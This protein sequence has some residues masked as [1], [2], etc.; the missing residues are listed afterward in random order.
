MPR[1]IPFWSSFSGGEVA[2]TIWLRPD[3]EKYKSACQRV[4]NY[5]LLPQGGAQRRPGLRHVAAAKTSSTC[6][7]VR[8]FVFSTT[9][10]YILEF[11]NLYCRFYNNNA[12]ITTSGGGGTTPVEVTT[13]YRAEDL[14]RL[15]VRAQSGDVLYCFHP[16]YA[17]RKIERYSNTCWRFR[18][19][20][21]VPP[22]TIEYGNRPPGHL[23]VS[24]VSGDN[25]TATSLVEAS[26]LASDVGREI[27]VTSGD[28]AGARAGIKAFTDTRTVTIFICEP[29]IS[30]TATCTGSWKIS[31]SPKTKLTLG[32]ATPVG[33]STTM[34]LTANG[35]RGSTPLDTG[36]YTHSDC[37]LYVQV[38]GGMLEIQTVTGLTVTN[39][40][41]RGEA[42]TTAAES[43]T[44]SIEETLF[45]STYGFPETGDFF[46]DRLWVNSQHRICGSV[47]GDYENFGLGVNDDDAVVFAINSREINTIRNIVGSRALQVFTA[48]GQFVAV[49]GT[50][51]PITPTNI[52]ISPETN[53]TTSGVPPIRVSESTLFVTG[54][55]R[56][57]REFT[58][59]QDVASDVYVAPDLLLLAEHLT[60]PGTIVDMAYQ[61]EPRSTIWVVRSDG[62]LLSCAYRREENV[63]AW[64]QHTTCGA[65]ESV[66]I[67]P[68][69]D[70]DREQVWVST[71][72]TVSGSTRRAVERFDD[73]TFYYSTLH[74]DAAVACN[75]GGTISTVGGLNHLA[76][77]GVKCIID[78]VEYPDQTVAATGILTL[79]ASGT[80]AEV[81]LPYISQLV[82]LRPELPIGG[83][84]SQ[85]RKMRWVELVLKVYR[86]IGTTVGTDEGHRYQIDFD[87]S[88]NIGEHRLTHLGWDCAVV[89]I[90]QRKPLPSTILS[91]TGTIDVGGA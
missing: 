64:A 55:G 8:P 27:V 58:V 5:L 48:G 57:L 6:V 84:T 78:G 74:T 79:P 61:R 59:R 72:R 88:C 46:D 70:G 32:A 87:D 24:A 86:T 81:G 66:A 41:I 37:G 56:Q 35:W 22:P 31:E 30:L 16:K 45:S 85:T 20:T 18:T 80:K 44:W 13:P 36:L 91:L 23:S 89:T 90:E 71:V 65:I 63:V 69:P 21:F 49:G 38:N 51:S 2:P 60:E 47:V 10:A 75:P 7:I 33:L 28:N 1:L 40:V 68:H 25:V 14:W 11:G 3:L 17:P 15:D 53:Y 19:V 62:T 50:D 83:E 4:L 82:P 39:G 52:R 67:I 9:Q 76:S 77:T 42:S 29:F 34:T 73:C 26:F 54:S 12:Q 43:G